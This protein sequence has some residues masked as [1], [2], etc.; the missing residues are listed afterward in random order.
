MRSRKLRR[1]IATFAVCGV[2]V[3]ACGSDSTS[4][5]TTAET[6]TETT[7]NTSAE[8]TSTDS[9]D[10]TMAEGEESSMADGE[11]VKVMVM[12]AIETQVL[13]IPQIVDGV[14][15]GAEDVNATGG[16]AGH[17][18]EVIVCND[19][20]D[21]NEAANC[22]R[23]AV[24]EGVIAAVGTLSIMADAMVPILE[25]AGIAM[26]GT[27]AITPLETVSP[28]AFPT[29]G[30]IYVTY[31]GIPLMLNQQAGAETIGIIHLDS[32][33]GRRSAGF[34]Q[35]GIEDSGLT[36][37]NVVAIP[38]GAADVAPQVAAAVEG[39]DA[40]AVVLAP[41]DAAKVFGVIAGQGLDIAIGTNDGALPPA[42]VASLG[43][44]TEGVYIASSAP[45]PSSLDAPGIQQYV[46]AAGVAGVE[47]D[48][49]ASDR[50]LAMKVL[51]SAMEGAETVD[52]ATVLERMSEIDCLSL[53]W[54]EC[55]T[56]TAEADIDGFTRIFNFN[57]YFSQV[58]DGAI[59]YVD[60]P[61]NIGG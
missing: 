43:A 15:A 35:A 38:D 6:D 11:P 32:D 47:P 24:D 1:T 2:L 28:I 25:E 23:E 34:V 41:Q 55:Y 40:I 10:D 5:D 50:W 42:L 39:A 3:A 44:P 4:D 22:A 33:S 27:S 56:T 57:A 16:I 60:G 14:N 48:G 21:P 30:G 13:S 17:P 45:P 8:E 18:V 26:V 53:A 31:T 51:Q 37:G 49:I 52:A 46:D 29:A 61:V 54:L 20:S 59:T 36:L 12:G 19:Q 7:T 58:Q 9:T